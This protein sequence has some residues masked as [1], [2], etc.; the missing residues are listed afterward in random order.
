MTLMEILDFLRTTRIISHCNLFRTYL[1]C[2]LVFY[3]YLTMQ[4]MSPRTNLKEFTKRISEFYTM[5]VD[6]NKHWSKNCHSRRWSIHY[7]HV[8]L[9]YQTIY[10]KH[11]SDCCVPPLNVRKNITKSFE[12]FRKRS[13]I[14]SLW[15]RDSSWQHFPQD[16]RPSRVQ[17][18]VRL[19]LFTP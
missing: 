8:E 13:N 18:H 2:T 4:Y 7:L 3:K 14:Y 16:W 11:T 5:Y 1:L 6:S 19:P 9:Y 12:Q 17:G 15:P 10:R